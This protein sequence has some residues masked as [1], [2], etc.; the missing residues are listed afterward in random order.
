MGNSGCTAS[1]IP[2]VSVA[3]DSGT[4]SGGNSTDVTVTFDS[5]GLTIG[6]TYTGTLCVNSNDAANPIVTVPLTLTVVPSPSI[7]LTKTVGTDSSCATTD[8]ITVT[9]GTEVTY[10]YTVTNDGDVTLDLHDLDDSDLGSLLSGFA[11]DLDPGAS[12]SITET[13]AIGVSTVNSATWTAS[14]S[15]LI[16]VSASATDT[17][18]VITV[19]PPPTTFYI[20]L[21]FVARDE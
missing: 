20:Y 5:T 16:G 4:T 19:E 8:T 11:Y 6:N 2:W 10:C 17:A 7:V 3:P 9:L 15:T 12:V 1:D 13:A 18:S 21:P 14:S